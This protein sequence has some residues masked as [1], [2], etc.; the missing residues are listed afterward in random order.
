MNYYAWSLGAIVSVALATACSSSSSGTAVPAPTQETGAMSAVQNFKVVRVSSE[1]EH[2]GAYIVPGIYNVAMVS[3]D[4][5]SPCRP[6]EVV[7]KRT[8]AEFPEVNFVVYK[9][10]KGYENGDAGS[11]ITRD[12]AGLPYIITYNP[13]GIVVPGF[14]LVENRAVGTDQVRARVQSMPRTDSNAAVVW[15]KRGA[16]GGERS[17]RS[18]RSTGQGTPQSADQL[19]RVLKQ[20]TAEFDAMKEMCE[21]SVI[22]MQRVTQ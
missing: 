19:P 13:S 16:P 4:Y 8:A 22:E 12:L 15:S 7:L 3:A 10:A 6:M 2:A 5:C 20:M 11:A 14:S 18:E 1:L 9:V 21:Q 17:T